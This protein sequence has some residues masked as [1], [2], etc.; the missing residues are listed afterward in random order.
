[1][2]KPIS[3][4]QVWGI[5][6]SSFEGDKKL[7]V[8]FGVMLFASLLTSTSGA[9]EVYKAGS[10]MPIVRHGSFLL[11][12]FVSCWLVAQLPTS[13]YRGKG[14][15][16]YSIFF[17]GLFVLLL[18]H[19][20]VINNAARWVDLGIVTVQPSEFF[21]ICLILWGAAVG[22]IS[23]DSEEER[24]W[25]FNIFWWLSLSVI[26]VFFF[27]NASTGVLLGGFLGVYSLIARMPWRLWLRRV[28]TLSLFGIIFAGTIALMPN[29]MIKRLPLISRATVWKTRVTDMLR[30]DTKEVRY[31]IEKNTQEKLGQVALA[32]GSFFGVGLGNSQT[33][34]FL[35]MAYTD[36]VL[37][38]MV[39]EMGL[40]AY[41]ILVGFYVAWFVLSG[42][43]AMAERN[44]YRRLLILGIGLFFPMQAI[45]NISVVSGLIVTGQTLPL[46]SWGGTSLM[47]TAIAMGMLISISRT[48]QEIQKLEQQAKEE[49]SAEVA[50]S[51]TVS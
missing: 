47:V 10:M 11:I 12:A 25:Y 6:K 8:L 16:W 41:I 14:L 18:V 32:N 2:S 21:K 35:P 26:A 46:I 45:V 33:R 23:Y 3:L 15:K 50:P 13:V 9:L 34:D 37:S 31:D 20:K 38:I 1:M 29:D 44:R 39:E 40:P 49:E 5:I 43:M 19:P 51:V 22:S 36:Y 30:N 42:R 17:G 48:Q 4:A 27:K 24:K 7:W 28:G